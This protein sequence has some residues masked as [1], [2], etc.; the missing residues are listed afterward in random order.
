MSG[1]ERIILAQKKHLRIPHAKCPPRP[2]TKPRYQT[3]PVNRELLFPP[4]GLVK[5]PRIVRTS[6]S[7]QRKSA[8]PNVAPIIFARNHHPDNM[9]VREL[10]FQKRIPR[11][12]SARRNTLGVSQRWLWHSKL[13]FLEHVEFIICQQFSLRGLPLACPSGD[14]DKTIAF[15]GACRVHKWPTSPRRKTW[16]SQICFAT[17]QHRS[18][19]QNFR[20][21]QSTQN[22]KICRRT[23]SGQ[24]KIIVFF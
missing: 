22:Y 9:Y 17:A 2:T 5:H 7:W 6:D 1:Q 20:V 12:Q 23:I 15:S 8:A 24:N 19:P 11:P 3:P 13:C 18:H 14:S 4:G 21:P 16:F 10:E